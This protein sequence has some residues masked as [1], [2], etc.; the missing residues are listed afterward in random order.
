MLLASPIKL[1]P[2]SRHLFILEA[3]VFSQYMWPFKEDVDSVF[4]SEISCH[5]LS[6]SKIQLTSVNEWRGKDAITSG[7]CNPDKSHNERLVVL[8]S[9]LMQ[10]SFP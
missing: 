8:P 6:R 3:Q 4:L 9:V 7:D 1:F 10:W 2:A 5:M